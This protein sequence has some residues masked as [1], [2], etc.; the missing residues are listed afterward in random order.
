MIVTMKIKVVLPASTDPRFKAPQIGLGTLMASLSAAD[1]L[2]V[3]AQQ[4]QQ[5]AMWE[6]AD[7]VVVTTGPAATRSCNLAEL[8]RLA[9]AHVVL[10]G[11]DLEQLADSEK[12]RQTVFLGS[13][14]ELW[15]AFLEDFRLG[16]AQHSYTPDFAGVLNHGFNDGG[17]VHAA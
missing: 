3:T 15:P 10:I 5:P 2:V 6:D 1:E 9:G 17:P 13:A 4:A 7:L 11:T 14:D 12:Q 8:Y 16:M